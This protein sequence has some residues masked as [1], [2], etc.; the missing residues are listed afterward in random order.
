MNNI[1]QWSSQFL[2]SIEKA[3]LNPLG[4]TSSYESE[5][6]EYKKA[7]VKKFK[8]LISEIDDKEI[9]AELEFKE[10]ILE[11]KPSGR[12]FFTIISKETFNSLTSSAQSSWL[13]GLIYHPLN[14]HTRGDVESGDILFC[15][16]VGQF[17]GLQVAQETRGI[18]GIGIALSNPVEMF[19]KEKKHKRWGI[20]VGFP[21]PLNTHLSQSTILQN[22]ITRFLTPYAGNRNDSLQKIEDKEMGKELLKMICSKNP[23]VKSAI[24]GFFHEMNLRTKEIPAKGDTRDGILTEYVDWFNKKE[25]FKE[26][27]AGLVSCEY[28]KFVDSTYFNNRLF[29][30]NFAII[31]DEITEIRNL[32][33]ENRESHWLNFNNNT[34]RGA[35]QAILGEH[36][37][38]KF[39]R[40]IAADP[41]H[42]ERI[43]NTY[44][45]AIAINQAKNHFAPK[46]ASKTELFKPF[47]LL[48]GIS[49]SG[50]T[51]F[52]KNQAM[53]SAEM[54]NLLRGENFCHLSV[55]PDWHEPSDL[56]G[57]ISRISG[58]KYV[59]TELIRFFVKSFKHC[60]K[61]LSNNVIKWKPLDEI[62]PFWLCLDEMNLAPV[63]QYL[64]D[65]LSVLETR[66]DCLFTNE[67]PSAI[68]SKCHLKELI[69]EGDAGKKSLSE[70][71]HF[72]FDENQSSENANNINAKI[73]NYIL[74]NG[75]PLPPNLII[76][77]TVNM[78]ETT[79]N[80]SRKVIDRAVTLDF[81]EFFPNE[82]SEYFDKKINFKRLSYPQRPFV[83]DKK[84]LARGMH[85]GNTNSE[86]P[87]SQY[88]LQQINKILNGT[89]FQL[90]FRALNELYI[91]EK[92]IR[93]K[94]IIELQ[95]IWD[96]FL[97][98]KV[99]PR[100]EGDNQKLKNIFNSNQDS[101]DQVD[102]T[103][104]K[105][106]L[107]EI[108]SV[109]ES[110]LLKDVW[111]NSERVDFLRFNS[112]RPEIML[113]IK[114]RTKNK[115][116]WMQ[117]RLERNLST[118]FW[119]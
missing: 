108:Y 80:F 63:E 4:L 56:F 72:I 86:M 78:D 1:D 99:L 68:L 71:Y 7:L 87:D 104:E 42:L 17:D 75:V 83:D 18:Y 114:C 33:Y 117:K 94:S 20:M 88:F 103:D 3:K 35:P 34:S 79:H 89:F 92:S 31:Q 116:V 21:F 64:S 84:L 109:C 53:L 106:I 5:V 8:K 25:N 100:I 27:Y 58:T 82:F 16:R 19:N 2:N 60:L 111:E 81:T 14:D 69:V 74:E 95:S 43:K 115:L 51:A 62:S 119:K 24:E 45:T 44:S 85:A 112:D 23:E 10:E 91:F 101:S 48:A 28:L 105:S 9:Q 52:V 98:M 110:D 113:N 12:D 37:Y 29:N 57:Y 38:I 39:L 55:R 107:E 118:D 76:A 90:G 36:N 15:H 11:S 41:K 47:L 93:P 6:E 66:T 102:P 59:P 50:K 49:G 22:Q 97:M 46:D 32:V 13:S 67:K 70:L 30:I 40:E 77:G 26:V 96:D 73:W 61:D 65:Y 54:H